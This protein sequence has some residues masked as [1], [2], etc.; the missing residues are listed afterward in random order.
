MTTTLIGTKRV[1]RLAGV[2]AAGVLVVL[3]GCS[4][5]DDASTSVPS[6]S[7]DA[8]ATDAADPAGTATP[9]TA[10]TTAPPE[11]APRQP[12]AITEDT[13]V[14]AA[15]EPAAPAD[16]AASADPAAP[17]ETAAAPEPTSPPTT[18]D[19]NEVVEAVPVE[20][21]APTPLVEPVEV[22]GT[23]RVEIVGVDRVEAE[24]RLPG[25]IAGP[26]LAVTV[27]VA[28]TSGIAI[29]LTGVT[30][31]LFDAA[32]TASAPLTSSPN[33]P[34]VGELAPGSGAE[35]VYLFDFGADRSEPITVEVSAVVGTPTAVFVGPV[36]S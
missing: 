29:D 26:S 23:A 9:E 32:G 36:P 16:P 33:A 6:A 15:T 13:A 20:T 8:A 1:T 18:G 5:D 25:E 4:D 21:L 10:E 34:L 28:N 7:A 3:S 31:N 17:A 35:G 11:T 2:L 14:T 12:G 19:I 22:Q 24:A 30:V 27:A